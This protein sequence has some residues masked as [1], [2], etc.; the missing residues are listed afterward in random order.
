[1]DRQSPDGPSVLPSDVQENNTVSEV[2][3][4]ERMMRRQSV[5]G[6]SN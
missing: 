1:M 4:T 3:V 2:W 6:P 5:N